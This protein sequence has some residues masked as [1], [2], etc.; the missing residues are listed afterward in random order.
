MP[1]RLEG[2]AKH[3]A[4]RVFVFDQQDGRCGEP[5]TLAKPARRHAGAARFFFDSGDGLGAIDNGFLE[6]VELGDDF[7]PVGRR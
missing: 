1:L 5:G 7:S 3:R 4:Q 2:M 6:T